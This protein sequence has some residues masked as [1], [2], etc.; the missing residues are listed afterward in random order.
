M[1]RTSV[2]SSGK[3]QKAN[4]KGLEQMSQVMEDSRAK[5]VVLAKG[6]LRVKALPNSVL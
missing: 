3:K 2:C 6:Q 5:A 4:I 1:N